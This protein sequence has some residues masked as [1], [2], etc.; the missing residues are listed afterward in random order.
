M[1]FVIVVA[2]QVDI[3][4]EVLWSGISNF[5]LLIRMLFKSGVLRCICLYVGPKHKLVLQ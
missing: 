4:L 1:N 3:E 2:D 5:I